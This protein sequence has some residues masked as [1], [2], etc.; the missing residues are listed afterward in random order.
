MKKRELNRRLTPGDRRHIFERLGFEF[1]G[2][3][4][5]EGWTGGLMGPAELGEGDSGDFAVNLSH[6]G[7]R[8]HGSTGFSGSLYDAVMAVRGVGFSEA[9]AWVAEQA[10]VASGGDGATAKGNASRPAPRPQ[11]PQARE[12]SGEP[13][14]IARKQVEAWNSALLNGEKGACRRAREFLT[15]T[16]GLRRKTLRAHLVGLRHRYGQWWICFPVVSEGRVRRVKRVAFDPAR[17]A[18]AG[19]DGEKKV[20]TDGGGSGLCWTADLESTSGPL[21]LCEGEIDAMHARQH[22]FAA[23]TG[24]AGANTFKEQWAREIARRNAS[25]VVVA[26]DGDEA[27]REGAQKAAGLLAAEGVD[28][29]IADLPDGRDVNDVLTEEGPER[30]REIV[31]EA[32]SYESPAEAQTDEKDST[33]GGAISADPDF[34]PPALYDL[35]PETL[36]AVMRAFETDRERA[37]FLAGALPV[38]AGACPNVLLRYGRQW[39]ALNLYFLAVAPAGSGKGSLRH[40]RRMG[41]KIHSRLVKESKKALQDWKERRDSEDAEAGPRPPMRT[42]YPAGDNS[43]AGLKEQLAANPHGVIFETEIKTVT[44]ALAQEWGQY[45]DVLLK[46]AHNETLTWKRKDKEPIHVERPAPAVALSGT[47]RS[48]SEIITDPEDGLFSRCLFLT[49]DGGTDFRNMFEDDSDTA[50]DAALS[51]AS[52][53]LDDLRKALE[54]RSEPLYAKIGDA[55]RKRIVAA[56]RYATAQVKR[57]KVGNHFLSNVRRAALAAFRVA[58]L[59]R[60]LRLFEDGKSLTSAHT[61]EVSAGDVEAG[62]TVALTCLEHAAFLSGKLRSEHRLKGLEGEKRAYFKALP[63]GTF[64]TAT[65]KTIAGQFSFSLR[66]A[67]R[68]LKTYV[69]RGLLSD[70]RH[71]KWRKPKFAPVSFLSFL[72]FSAETDP[73]TSTEGVPATDSTG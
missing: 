5:D 69:E 43:A 41:E 21:L 48:F 27:G 73:E 28:V 10:G 30:L 72:S 68:H 47:P 15:E 37:V 56:G 52:E 2:H 70:A 23:V 42:L 71:G 58:G 33:G 50:L 18:W 25:E 6:G 54:K 66:T 53:R 51:T 32:T 1:N 46:G 13:E 35:L 39:L 61:V 63:A 36:R 17:C 9:L 38:L 60:V 12:A 16:R 11:Q 19:P 57:S 26:Y 49:F 24:T 7:V 45:R 3:A 62:L 65:A 29:R 55:G 67:Q 4:R 44:T 8:D 59:L 20:R 31:G 40:A 22:G 14:G 64:D 34:F